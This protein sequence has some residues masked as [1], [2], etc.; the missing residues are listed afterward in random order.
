VD[1]LTG[2]PFANG[3]VLNVWMGDTVVGRGG[4]GVQCGHPIIVRMSSGQIAPIELDL[5]GTKVDTVQF[6]W[7]RGDGKGP[8]SSIEGDFVEFLAQRKQIGVNVP[9]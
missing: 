8:S 3:F 1:C 2:F 5:K 4:M 6:D 9:G 7:L